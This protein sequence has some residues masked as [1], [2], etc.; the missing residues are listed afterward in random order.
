MFFFNRSVTKVHHSPKVHHI[1][2][3]TRQTHMGS[4]TALQGGMC[5]TQHQTTYTEHIRG[6]G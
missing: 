5:L 2:E 3:K 6:R 1:V 4:Q